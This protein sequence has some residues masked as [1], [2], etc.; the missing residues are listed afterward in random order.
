M[1]GCCEIKIEVRPSP[2]LS[3]TRYYNVQYVRRYDTHQKSARRQN[4]ERASPV[5]MPIFHSSALFSFAS[6]V[7]HQNAAK[8]AISTYLEV[9]AEEQ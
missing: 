2:I 8:K 5:C 6:Q 1:S 7:S 4:R 3:C 9:L